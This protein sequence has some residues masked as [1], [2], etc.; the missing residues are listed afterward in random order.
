MSAATV[1]AIASGRRFETPVTSAAIA[2]ATR[3][4]VISVALSVPAC[5][6]AWLASASVAP[7]PRPSAVRCAATVAAAISARP[8]S[9]VPASSK[10][11]AARLPTA[12]QPVFRA[13]RTFTTG[14]APAA[15][16]QICPAVVV[17]GGVAPKAQDWRAARIRFSSARN[18]APEWL[19]RL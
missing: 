16:T 2:S 3:S 5:A 9:D 1:G 7:A 13:L 17:G 15:S 19:A 12:I 8:A 11:A 14:L 6:S 4:G 10:P 18:C